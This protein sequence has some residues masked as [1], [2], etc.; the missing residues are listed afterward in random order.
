MN[1]W[2]LPEQGKLPFKFMAHFLQSPLNHTDNDFSLKPL[3]I[4]L[5]FFSYEMAVGKGEK[6]KLASRSAESNFNC[7]EKVICIVYTAQ[8]LVR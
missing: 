6:C 5:C 1:E 3:I 2:S 8:V 4:G 7:V